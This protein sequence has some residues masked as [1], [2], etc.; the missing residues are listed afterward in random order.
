MSVFDR[1]DP[2]FVDDVINGAR[3]INRA[4]Y[5]GGRVSVAWRASDVWDLR[6]SGMTQQ[7]DGHGTPTEDFDAATGKLLYGELQQAR[8]PGTGGIKATYGLYDVRVEGHLGWADLVAATSYGKLT[9]N[10]NTDATAQYGPLLGAA[11]GQSGIGAAIQGN[12]SLGKVSQEL[13]LSSSTEQRFAW[14]TGVFYTHEHSTVTQSLPTFDAA[15]GGPLAVSLPNML[16]VTAPSSFEE[17]AVFADVTYRFTSR[18]DVTSGFRYSHNWQSANETSSGLLVGPASTVNLASHDSSWTYLV[19]PRFHFDERSMAYLRLASGYR[20]GGPN[21]VV[22]DVPP[23]YRPDTVINYEAG[24]K[25]D[26]FDRHLSLDLAVFY[27]DWNDVQL[28]QESPLGTSYF[29]N[30]GKASSKG[31]EGTFS[32]RPVAGLTLEGN[33][34]RIEA[35]LGRTLPLPAIGTPGDALPFTPHWSGQISAEY[36][37]P[38]AGTWSGQGGASYRFVGNRLSDFAQA[39]SYPRFQLPSY[40]VFD[41]RLGVR[42][43]RLSFSTYVKNVGDARGQVNGILFGAVEEVSMIQPRTVGVSIS[44]EF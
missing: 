39:G 16:A 19:T 35:T 4:R 2:G 5:D 24:L 10:I 31:T 14:Q 29:S 12:S 9:S 32:W 23:S 30:A 36:E 7:L 38:L 21:I 42:S 22:T 11:L 33:V 25:S 1:Q 40:Q 43:D 41:L 15:T 20:P 8:A 28:R 26:L 44:T 37:L 34:S 17:A 18:L 27:I 3:N 13:R 6:F